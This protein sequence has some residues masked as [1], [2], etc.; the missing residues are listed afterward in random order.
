MKILF[1]W[2]IDVF[3]STLNGD[4]AAEEQ[5]ANRRH[6]VKIYAAICQNFL[7]LNLPRKI[8]FFLDIRAK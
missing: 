2:Q 4:A 3:F 5:S 7:Y 1:G 6:T 8:R